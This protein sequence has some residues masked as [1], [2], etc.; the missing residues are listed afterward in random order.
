MTI[1]TSDRRSEITSTIRNYYKSKE[2]ASSSLAKKNGGR[3]L[4]KKGHVD[5]S[6]S[7]SLQ[8]K[9]TKKSIDPSSNIFS[10]GTH[11]LIEGP[12]GVGKTTLL[13][14]LSCQEG[15]PEHL[16]PIRIRLRDLTNTSC[17]EKN[18]D[19]DASPLVRLIYDSF[20]LSVRKQIS[21]EELAALLSAK[22][23]IVPLLDGLDEVSVLLAD[24]KSTASEVLEEILIDY[25][26]VI[27]TVRP[28][29]L[30]GGTVSKFDTVL[31]KLPLTA[32]GVDR[33]ID[34][35]LEKGDASSLKDFLDHNQSIKQISFIP[36]NIEM[37]CF[38]WSRGFK[39]K[40]KDTKNT[41]NLSFVYDELL[42]C[43]AKRHLER[44][45]NDSEELTPSALH[46][47]P[48]LFVNEEVS[49]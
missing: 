38:M 35:A 48:E 18:E 14:S 13:D 37:I 25:K 30:K 27:A 19:E 2:G 41:I 47:L 28:G 44:F 12:A 31:E 7:A 45:D 26:H 9:G 15:L 6:D 42:I 36:V 4:K 23:L 32:D 3:L 20:P 5:G 8:V 49:L 34:S 21:I 1:L 22:E 29:S 24:S 10:E 40:V 39:D 16:V 46:N 11:V 17:L 33:F 43:L